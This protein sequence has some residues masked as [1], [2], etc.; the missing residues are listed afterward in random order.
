MKK[1]LLTIFLGTATAFAVDAQITDTSSVSKDNTLYESTTGALS[2]GS[3]AH[4]FAG[5]TNNGALRRAVLQFDLSNIPST[6]TITNVILELRVNRQKRGPHTVNVHRLS[7]DWG[8]GASNASGQEGSGATASSNDAT[9]IHTFNST[10]TWNTAGGDF[11]AT[12]SANASVN[13]SNALINFSGNQ[14]VTDVQDWIDGTNPNFGWILVGDESSNASAKRF[15]SKDNG[16]SANHPRL[17]ITYNNSTSLAEA[18]TKEQLVLYPNPA[19]DQIK[20]KGN[21]DQYNK[22]LRILNI[23]GKLVMQQSINQAGEVN[24]SSLSEG[25]YFLELIDDQGQLKT[26]PF[27]KK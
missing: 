1:I 5:R 17:I 10:G 25:S 2:N 7:A 24:I 22:Q 26:F 9:W 8:E 15:A 27:I 11:V 19:V 23:D 16:N 6:A 21:F 14:L 4:I 3:G 13:S 12:S 20:L 18:A